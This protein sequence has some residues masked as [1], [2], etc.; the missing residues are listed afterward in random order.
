MEQ[1]LKQLTADADAAFNAGETAK[2]SELYQ[3]VLELDPNSVAAHYGIGTIALQ[4]KDLQKSV[5]HLK[6]AAEIEPEAVDIAFNLATCLFVGGNRVGALVQLERAAKYCLDDPVF[7]S[8]IA[9]MS[10]RLGEPAAA[11][12]IMSRLKALTPDHQ[13][14]IAN[15]H[16][17]LGNWREA[18]GI[19]KNLQKS[20]PENAEIAQKLALAAGQ[21]RDYPFAISSYQRYLRLITPSANDYL[22]FADLLLIA[23]NTKRCDQA[24]DQALALGEDSAELYVLRARTARLRGDYEAVNAALD[25]ALNRQANHGQAWAIKAEL[26]DQAQLPEF[27]AKLR[28]QTENEKDVTQ[29]NHHLQALLNYSLADMCD[30]QADYECATKALRSANKLQNVA[31]ALTNTSYS[32]DATEQ[33]FDELIES[34][35]SS[36]FESNDVAID[37]GEKQIT[38]I[39]IVGMARSGT[40]LVERILGQNP[41]V[42]NAGEQEAMEFVATHYHYQIKN[43]RLPKP[44]DMNAEQRAALRSMYLEKLPDISKPIF[45]DKLPHNF[46]QVGLI[47]KLFPEARVIQM[48]RAMPDVC[49]SIYSHAFAA[50]HNYATHWPDMLHFYS[51]AERLMAHW[52]SVDSTRVMNLNYEDLAE[53]PE[54]YAK[55]IVEFCGFEWQQSYLDFHQSTTQSFTFSEMQVRQPISAT[56]ID[57]WRNY[58]PYLPELEV[59]SER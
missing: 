20:L 44:A 56:R 4:D 49:L 10:I 45:T 32:K 57:R 21:L 12:T 8:R 25:Q 6:R 34:Y 40:T 58:L 33:Q 17:V 13:L 38:P 11:V 15:A 26:A 36:V 42:F 47:L 30:R 35:S 2:A 22:R 46:R 39:F 53:S 52:S 51:Q 31:L 7:C 37:S 18:I 29:L 3:Q 19:L 43:D 50:G 9:E 24:L 48:H 55:K 54:V 14:I 16:G 23:Q 1:E 41:H 5:E 28:E 59:F 27:I